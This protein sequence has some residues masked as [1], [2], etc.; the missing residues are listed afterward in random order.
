MSIDRQELIALLDRFEVRQL[1]RHSQV[2]AVAFRERLA[3]AI[4]ELEG[5]DPDA[6]TQ[7]QE[8]EG[9][10][11]EHPAGDQGRQAAE[12]GGGDRDAQ[13]GEE[14]PTPLTRSPNN[15]KLGYPDFP[16]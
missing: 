15:P 2:E 3:D 12:A 14:S 1:Y 5:G 9:D 6:A 8:Q 11:L 4:L 7:G 16:S 13:G 10:Q